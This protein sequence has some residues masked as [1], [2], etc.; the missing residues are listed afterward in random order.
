MCGVSYLLLY[1]IEI[2][3]H[4]SVCQEAQDVFVK[5]YMEKSKR[6]VSVLI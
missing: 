2:L 5:G 3:H 4:F 6:L 1:W